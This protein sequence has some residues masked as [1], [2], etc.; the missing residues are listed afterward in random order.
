MKKALFWLLAVILTLSV[1]RY[2]RKTGP[3]YP[4]PFTLEFQDTTYAFELLR[5]HG[6]AED[7]EIR[8]TLPDSLSGR[9]IYRRYPGD[10]PWDTVQM[11]RNG[12][13]L[14]GALPRQSP[15]GK[16]EYHIELSAE[17]APVPIPGME[18]V[19]IRFKGR[20]PAWALVPHILFMFTALLLS[21]LTGLY[22]VAG[23]PEYRKWM[24]IAILSFILGGLVF[25]PIV[26][27]Y[28]FDAF[29]TGW[30]RGQDLTDNKVLF[31][32]IPWLIAWYCNRKKDRRWLVVLA[33]AGL[34]LAFLIP[35]SMHGSQLNYE[36]GMIETG[37]PG[38]PQPH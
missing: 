37:A 1:S 5:T 36:T 4:K 15:A 23:L 9:I 13:E 7:C 34:L 26:Q 17:K 38:N 12:P 27:K 8:L 29:W 20:V 24:A 16:L 22:A 11:V 28:A 30:P 14:T 10:A 3:T 21:T 6:G 33:S 32:L 25:G 18:N 2:Q 31:A 19:I 35:H